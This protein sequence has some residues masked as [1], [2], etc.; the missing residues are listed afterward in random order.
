MAGAAGGLGDEEVVHDGHARTV[1]ARP[2]PLIEREAD[3]LAVV[4]GRDE[5]KGMVLGRGDHRARHRLELLIGRI[6]LVELDVAPQQR[7]ERR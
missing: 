7:R 6:G 3:Q 2:L 4:I 5:Q 1:E